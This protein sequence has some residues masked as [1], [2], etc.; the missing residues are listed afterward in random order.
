MI[1]STA[2]VAR[3]LAPSRRRLSPD[4]IVGLACALALPLALLLA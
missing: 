4:A 2:A 1:R 3:P